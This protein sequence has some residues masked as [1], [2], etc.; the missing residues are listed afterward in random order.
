MHPATPAAPP[1]LG[2]GLTAL[3]PIAHGSTAT[4]Y[5]ALQASVGRPVAVKIDNRTL[6][7]ERDR[8]RFRDEANATGR[9]SGHPHVIDLFDAAVSPAG[10]PYLVMELCNGSYSD[11]VGTLSPAQVRSVGIR[12]ASALTAA[13]AAGVLHRDVKPGNILHTRFGTPVLADFGLA[14]LL[15]Q[16]DGTEAL[17]PLTP[18]Y[19]AP[20]SVADAV[21]LPSGDVY[22]LAATLYALLGGYPPRLPGPGVP[23]TATLL[24]LYEQPVPGLPGVPDAL[25]AVLRQALSTDPDRR[26]SAAE[27]EQL[28]AGAAVSAPPEP[29]G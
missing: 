17:D 27:F 6:D 2:P 11:D 23:T 24:E 3:V 25:L 15:D 13:H 26:P 8:R 28:L 16:R 21:A 9:V 5:R 20:E 1:T 14:V 12:I 22:S 29:V 19:A 18:A 10:H 7:T 4:V